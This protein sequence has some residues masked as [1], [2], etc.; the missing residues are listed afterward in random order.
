MVQHQP[1][2]TLGEST[3]RWTMPYRSQTKSKVERFNR[4][5]GLCRFLWLRSRAGRI[6]QPSFYSAAIPRRR[7]RCRWRQNTID[8]VDEDQVGGHSPIQ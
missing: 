2:P 8:R 4:T 6:L 7:P 3:R 5:A 1:Q